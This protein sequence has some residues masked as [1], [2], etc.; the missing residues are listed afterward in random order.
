MSTVITPL[1]PA[2]G[3]APGV[4]PSPSPASQ[5]AD[6][7]TI[8]SRRKHIAVAILSA[9]IAMILF[10]V[11][12]FH[13]Y[14]AWIIAHPYVAPLTSNPKIAKNLDY[15]DVSFPSKSGHT[16]VHG[17][18]I[19]ATA[20]SSELP[21]TLATAAFK[22]SGS[23][24][25]TTLAA[26]AAPSNR[27]IVFSHGYGANREETWVPMYDLANLLHRLHY[28]V[29]MFD[30]GYAS[31]TDRSPATG[32]IEESKQ[33]LAAVQYARSQGA[34]Q[35]VV[36]GFS[37]GAGT[38]LQAALQ[39]DSTDRIDAL[40]LDS[41][42]LTSP[43]SLYGNVRQ[44]LDLPRYPSMPLIEGMLHFFTGTDF[45]KIPTEQVISTAY[46][47]PMYIMHGT[48]DVKAPLA[49]AEKIASLQSNLLS[50]EWI[51]KGG[52]HEMLFQTRSKEYIQRAALFLSQ[53]DAARKTTSTT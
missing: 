52:K 44:Y 4:L 2:G 19:P 22:T 49:T 24:S 6:R 15:T 37:M 25:P 46:N 40:L 38:A 41:L 42:F 23:A 11:L 1:L 31:S 20:G 10:A 13:G 32:G 33:L 28:N 18:Y 8:N 53:V 30:Y 48:D 36:W 16:N 34:D 12:A 39:T 17:W 7:A 35:V 9:F 43:E 47:I 45:N 21:R 29:F 50:R 51:V 14:V 27:T 3:F 5:S 26:A